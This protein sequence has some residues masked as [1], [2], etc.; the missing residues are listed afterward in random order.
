MEIINT[1]RRGHGGAEYYSWP[2]HTLNSIVPKDYY[3]TTGEMV[4][5]TDRLLLDLST[6][7][8]KIKSLRKELIKIKSTHKY[9]ESFID[10]Q[11]DVFF[12]IKDP[13]K[14]TVTKEEPAK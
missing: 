7:T 3:R 12:M 8:L 10:A 5:K 6:L 9:L 14:L 4:L 2:V 1:G 13:K 11:G